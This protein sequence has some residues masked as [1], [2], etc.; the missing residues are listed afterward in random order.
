MIKDLIKILFFIIIRAVPKKKN[1]LAF[2]DRAG[3][4]FAD[5]SRYLYFFINKH[6]PE[7]KCVWITKNK[8][9]GYCKTFKII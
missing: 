3:L 8:E 6:H 1:L 4:T 9:R 5:N 2:G 7:F